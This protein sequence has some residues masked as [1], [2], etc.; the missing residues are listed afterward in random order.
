MVV[1]VELSVVP[2]GSGES[3]SR[4]V[5]EAVKELERNGVKYQ[6]TP[7]CTIFEASTIG[8]AFKI[9]EA[10]HEAVFKAGALRVITSVKVDDRRDK[11]RA[12]ME[13][14]VKALKEKF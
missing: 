5:A 8:E 7:M 4:F 3:V 13:E 12:S 1:V 9:V 2:L 6:V 10:A 11:P 14:K